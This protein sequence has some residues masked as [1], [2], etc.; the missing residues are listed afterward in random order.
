VSGRESISI[1][2][3]ALSH[4]LHL[5]PLG[6]KKQHPADV[7]RSYRLEVVRMGVLIFPVAPQLRRDI[8]R[9]AE[10]EQSTLRQI[11][12]MLMYEGVESYNREG[13]KFM[14]KLLAKQKQRA[15]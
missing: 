7:R 13:S 11:C 4:L 6:S 8:G 5:K 9:I 10:E 2:G 1:N 15:K 14:Q 12:K 3:L